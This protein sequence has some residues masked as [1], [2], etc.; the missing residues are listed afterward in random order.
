VLEAIDVFTIIN[1]ASLICFDGVFTCVGGCYKWGFSGCLISCAR[2]HRHWWLLHEVGHLLLCQV[3]FE[4][5][6]MTGLGSKSSL[7]KVSSECFIDG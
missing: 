2:S 6:I 7:S 3:R 5:I 4:I 1:G